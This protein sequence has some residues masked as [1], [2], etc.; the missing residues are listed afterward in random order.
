MSFCLIH[1]HLLFYVLDDIYRQFSLWWDL[2]AKKKVMRQ[3][4]RSKISF[5]TIYCMYVLTSQ[6]FFCRT[7]NHHILFFGLKI[8]D[9]VLI[10]RQH[11]G[12]NHMIIA[13]Y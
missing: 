1:M 8:R 5:I 12:L 3:V 9:R 10:H 2:L 6:L 13:N 4:I 7:R 11:F